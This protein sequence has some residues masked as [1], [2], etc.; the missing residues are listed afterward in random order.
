MANKKK[1]K[2]KSQKKDVGIGKAISGV[3]TFQIGLELDKQKVQL[4]V[5]PKLSSK[6][7]Q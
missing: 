7:N 2:R 5:S 3:A 1:K 6:K 4:P